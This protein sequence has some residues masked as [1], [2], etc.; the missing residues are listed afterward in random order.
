MQEVNGTCTDR[1]CFSMVSANPRVPVGSYPLQGEGREDE[2]DYCLGMNVR[3]YKGQ[4]PLD[5][6]TTNGDDCRNKRNFNR[7]VRQEKLTI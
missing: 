7:S 3:E 6:S 4:S 5:I 1:M 2:A